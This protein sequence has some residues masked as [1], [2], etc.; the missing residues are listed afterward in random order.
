MTRRRKGS[1]SF[2]P[3][4][5][6]AEQIDR[7][8]EYRPEHIPMGSERSTCDHCHLPRVLDGGLCKQ[9]RH[10]LGVGAQ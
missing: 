4:K 5:D 8:G 9:C 1:G 10:L 2:A 3:M 6:V 7:D